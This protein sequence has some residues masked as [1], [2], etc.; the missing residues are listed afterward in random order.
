MDASI[1]D[2]LNLI[3]GIAFDPH[4][5]AILVVLTGVVILC[6][7]IWLILGT[8]VGTRLGFLLSL[9]G[10]FGWMTIIGI[11]WWLTPP[12][13]GPRG[14]TPS[15]EVVDIVR[16]DPAGGTAEIVQDLPNVC[17][18]AVTA[19]C[20]APEG[21]ETVA[22]TIIAGNEELQAEFGDE[23]APSLSEF[24]T[25]DP[26]IADDLD[27][28]D[29]ELV[30][31]ADSGEALAAA[32][33]ELRAAGVFETSAGYYVLD[34]WEQGGKEPLPDDP[35]RLDRIWHKIT[36]TA[37]VT[38]PPHYAVIQMVPVVP[39]TAEPGEAPPPPIPNS[40]QPVL[41]IVMERNLGNLRMPAALVTIGSALMLG[42]VCVALHRRDQL[43]EE[44]LA[45]G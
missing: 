28:G 26:T 39:Q 3:G 43:T 2:S 12:A 16:G 30:S 23:A 1:L 42:V 45:A 18:S 5:R 17:W 19:G 44:H 32:D 10:L 14:E 41:T 38:H 9:G 34:G 37:Q 22:G 29:W 4:I 15:W 6:G 35:T 21:G 36:S 24:L 8:N 33:E 11:T 20:E 25:I 27:F 13:I 31:T 7:S 40:E